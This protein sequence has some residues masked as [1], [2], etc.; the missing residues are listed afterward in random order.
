MITYSQVTSQLGD[1]LDFTY[2]GVF[3]DVIDSL[4]PIMDFWGLLFRALGPSECFGIK[5]FRAK[6]M[7]RVV[8]LPMVLAVVCTILFAHNTYKYGTRRAVTLAKGHSFVSQPAIQCVTI[9]WPYDNLR[10]GFVCWWQMAIFF[11]YPTICIVSFAAFICRPMTPS[12]SILEADDS[13]IC[14]NSSHRALQIVSGVVIA[15]VA[16]GIPLYFSYTL[17]TS[18]RQYEQTSKGPN[19]AMAKRL[20]VEMDT[21]VTVA[22]YVIRDIQIGE[23]YSFLMD[24]YIPKYLYWC[25]LVTTR[26]GQIFAEQTMCM[27]VTIAGRL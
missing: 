12:N 10:D 23:D 5:G 26:V 2:P 9:D 16:I 15:A 7:L 11:C 20:A 21:H 14:E 25:V 22:E 24:G 13:I 27:Y 19:A 1:V 6:W 17:I 8:G 18:A 4:R 3:G